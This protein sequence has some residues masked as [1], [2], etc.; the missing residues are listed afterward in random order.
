MRI[1]T[2]LTVFFLQ[3]TQ[4]FAANSLVPSTSDTQYKSLADKFQAG[5]LQL[6]D[7]PVYIKYLT[8]KLVWVAGLLAVL[9]IIW[10]SYKYLIGGLTDD[11]KGAKTIFGNVFKG[12]AFVVLAW[13]IIDLIVRFA[14]E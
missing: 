12:L 7:V 14:T 1:L 9:A 2:I 11:A 4:S 10:G 5:T 13:M 8:E 6:Y 3:T